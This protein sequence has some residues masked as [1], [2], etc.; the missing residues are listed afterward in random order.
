MSLDV[1][2]EFFDRL[3]DGVGADSRTYRALMNSAVMYDRE[4][5]IQRRILRIVV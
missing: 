2:S 1:P 3:L 5:G 4:P